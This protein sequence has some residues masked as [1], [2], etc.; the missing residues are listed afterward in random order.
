MEED[1]WQVSGKP[2]LFQTVGIAGPVRHSAVVELVLEGGDESQSGFFPEFRERGFKTAS[3]AAVPGTAVHVPKIAEHEPLCRAAVTE[4]HLHLGRRIRHQDEIAQWAP[5]S[6]GD[7]APAVDHGVGV[8]EANALFEAL[9]KF[10]FRETLSPDLTGEI[11]RDNHHEW[12]S[13]NHQA[14]P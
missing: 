6:R 4:I 11:A 3:R 2:H 14:K 9:A 7:R 5:G 12:P 13:V 10:L 8:R 1:A